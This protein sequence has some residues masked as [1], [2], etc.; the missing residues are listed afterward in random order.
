V[1]RT[2]SAARSVLNLTALSPRLQPPPELGGLERE[3][4]VATVAALDSHHFEAADVVLL[5]AYCRAAALE[6]RAAEELQVCAVED[7][8][9][10]PWLKVHASAVRSLASLATKLKLSPQARK[11]N[12]RARFAGSSS[13]YD[14]QRVGGPQWRG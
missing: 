4:F 6:R 8:A 12:H 7:G 3:V 9:P 11:P 13:Y 14:A 1:P 2:S 5:C 10:S